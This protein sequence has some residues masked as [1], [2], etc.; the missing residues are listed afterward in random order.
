MNK[1]YFDINIV[2]WITH[3]VIVSMA[4]NAIGVGTRWWYLQ[5]VLPGDFI[6]YYKAAL[7]IFDN[8]W[9]YK[10]WIAIIFKPLLIWDPFTSYMYWAGFQTV[11][12]IILTH[13]MFEVKYGFILVWITI[14]YFT[15]LLQVGNIQ[16]T[17]ALAAISPFP[18][19]LGL[20]VKPHYIVF[21]ISHAVAS[22]YRVRIESRKSL[23]KK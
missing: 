21:S 5:H 23:N 7:G 16:I 11:C 14:P 18:S 13:K 4:I 2:E 17:L 20:L 8:G 3:I 1:N 10:D 22:R 12:F 15:D 9:I 6:L 19:V